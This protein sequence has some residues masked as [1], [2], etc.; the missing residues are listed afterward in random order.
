MALLMIGFIN[1]KYMSEA[2]VQ[3]PSF[4]EIEA[5]IRELN[6]DMN[7]MV[8]APECFLERSDE[9]YRLI[10]LRDEMLGP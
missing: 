8:H 4:A 7:D 3:K 9:Q 1:N 2:L 10:Q 6:I 5:R